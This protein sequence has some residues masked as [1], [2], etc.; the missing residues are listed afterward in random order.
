MSIRRIASSPETPRGRSASR[1]V[2]LPLIAAAVVVLSFD[3]GSSVETQSVATVI[4]WWVLLAGVGLRIWPLERIPRTAV[5]AGLLLAA[6]VVFAGLSTLWAP[7]A[8][9]AL[10][11]LGRLSL[12]LG[13]FGLTVVAVRRGDG[14]RWADGLAAGISIAGILALAQRLIPGFAGDGGIAVQLPSAAVRLSYP[15]GYWNGLAIFLALAVP[16]L[17]RAAVAHGRP[18]ARA[19]AVVPVPVLAA[20]IYLTSSRGGAVVAL[21]GVVVFVAA[22]SRRFAAVQAL[23]VAGAGAAAALAVLTARPVLVDGPLSPSVVESQ[24]PT[25]AL[26]IAAIS[27]ATG[28]VYAVVASFVPNRI[29]MRPAVPRA[30]L[31]LLGVLALAAVIALDPAERVEAFKAPPAAPSETDFVRSHLFSGGGSGRWQFWGAAV[32]QFEAQPVRGEG[33]GSYEPWWAQHGSLPYFV[34]NAHSLWLETLGE[35][36]VVGALLL[37]GAFGTGLIAAARRLRGPTEGDRALVA[38]LAAC[39]LAFIAGAAIDWVWQ[40]PVIGLV[41]VVVLGLLVGPATAAAGAAGVSA[42]VRRASLAAL[43]LAGIAV[44]VLQAALWLGDSEL[45]RSREAVGRGALQEALDR[46]ASAR[47]IQ[48]WAASPRAQVALV[49]EL[50]GDLPAARRAIAEAIERDEQDWRL[51][52]VAARLATKDGTIAEARS[53]LRNARELNPRSALIRSLR[54]P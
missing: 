34:R 51:R 17:L 29:A 48:P 53:Q 14:E 47:A 19:V 4:L 46:A 1:Y 13:A 3:G 5:V 28:A 54:Q 7:S 41:A 20:A 36:G 30:V 27:V 15:L 39:L 33:A 35:L 38:A 49:Y 11:G 37:L 24:G 42:P 18:L 21:L 16:L 10:A 8:E 44:I 12:Y 9:R 32:D 23:A 52:V 31:V 26:L 6:F 50:A 43:L 45:R 2:Q 22:T 40:L 25:V